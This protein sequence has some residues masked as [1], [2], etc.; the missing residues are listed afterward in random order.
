MAQVVDADGDV[1]AASPNVAGGPAVVDARTDIAEDA[2]SSAPSTGPDDDETERYRVWTGRGRPR[3][4][5]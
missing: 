5:T 3:T 2:G 1:V 4:A